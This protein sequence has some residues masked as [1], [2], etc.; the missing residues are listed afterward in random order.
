MNVNN[1]VVNGDIRKQFV[2]NRLGS[3]CNSGSSQVLATDSFAELTV[4]R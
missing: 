4:K 1:Y 2:K 3:Q